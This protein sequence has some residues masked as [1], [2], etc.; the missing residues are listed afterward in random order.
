LSDAE[1]RILAERIP[2]RAGPGRKR[3]VD[4]RVIV[5]GLLYLDRTGC[6]WRAVPKEYGPWTTVRYYFDRWTADG[7]WRRLNDRL[8][9]EARVHAGRAAQPSA[10]IVDSQT[11]KTSEVGGERGFDGGKKAVGAQAPYLGGHAGQ[12]AGH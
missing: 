12:P 4:L 8:R 9:E 7:T 6:Q 2:P 10:A 3:T 1:W 11:A 5:N